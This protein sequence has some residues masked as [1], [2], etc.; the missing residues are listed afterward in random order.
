MRKLLPLAGAV[1]LAQNRMRL[2]HHAG[3]TDVLVLGGS[4]SYMDS[5]LPP[6]KIRV[7]HLEYPVNDFVLASFTF[8]QAICIHCQA[9][10]RTKGGGMG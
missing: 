6:T 2:A 8:T 5:C 9:H 3:V 4:K 10:S 7:W 1:F